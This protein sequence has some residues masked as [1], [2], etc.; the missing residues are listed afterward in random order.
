MMDQFSIKARLVMGFSAI[1]VMFLAFIGFTYYLSLDMDEHLDL[2]TD[3]VMVVTSTANDMDRALGDGQRA[4]AFA[5]LARDPAKLPEMQREIAAHHQAMNEAV[6]QYKAALG[7]NVH[8]TVMTEMFSSRDSDADRAAARTRAEAFEQRWKAYE[9]EENDILALAQAGNFDAAIAMFVSRGNGDFRALNEEI[10]NMVMVNNEKGHVASENAQDVVHKSVLYSPIVAVIALVVT[11]IIAML[12]I[13]TIHTSFCELLRVT[14]MMARGDLTHRVNINGCNEFAELA[15]SSNKMMLNMRNLIRQI[16]DSSQQVAAA[17]EEL[18]ANS[19]QSASVSQNI[20]QSVVT[21][22]TSAAAQ[23]ETMSDTVTMT[24]EVAIDAQ[25]TSEVVRTTAEQTKAA[26][27]QARDGRDL[28]SVTVQQMQQVAQE[29]EESAKVVAKLGERSKEIGQI[30]E[31]ISAISDQTNLLALNAAIEAA[32]AGEAGRGFSV[33]AEEVRKLAAQSQAS[34]QHIGT[35]I[36]SIQEDTLQAVEAMAR[37]TAKVKDGSAS[38]DSLGA[39]FETIHTMVENISQK[40]AASLGTFHA[41]E[42]KIDTIAAS[43][44]KI[45]NAAK[46]VSDDAQ[47]VS[48]SVEE[49]SAGMEDIASSASS[50]STLAQDLDAAIGKFRV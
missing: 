3:D 18:H 6:E 48:A 31:S 16:Q 9:K 5:L 33:V 45:V 7:A 50:L 24:D 47:T 36:H 27:S 13:R 10:D 1:V 14:E 12:L 25:S 35:L 30:V 42:E 2:I 4:L 8:H 26:V 39:A 11:I 23:L 46:T 32:R 37:G 22:S 28:V 43:S 15:E 17:A 29:V 41:L 40:A 34:A 21:M 20:A 44:V 49:Q 38:V 19:Q